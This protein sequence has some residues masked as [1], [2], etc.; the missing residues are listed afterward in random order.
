MTKI[1]TSAGSLA[2]PAPKLITEVEDALLS[3]IIVLCYIQEEFYAYS[4]SCHCRLPDATH[5]TPQI[6]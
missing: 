3:D 2:G 1:F 4:P 6:I 5:S